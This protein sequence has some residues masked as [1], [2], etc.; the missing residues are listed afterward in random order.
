MTNILGIVLG[1]ALYAC[2]G[3]G[4]YVSLRKLSKYL[5]E[6]VL[7]PSSNISLYLKEID[8]LK[9]S[10]VRK[11]WMI[12]FVLMNFFAAIFSFFTFFNTGYFNLI[13]SIILPIP[14]LIPS[15]WIT[16]YC[17]YKKR[18]SAWLLYL[19]ISLP[20]SLFSMGL[21]ELVQPSFIWSAWMKIFSIIYLAS[22]IY[23][24]ITSIKLRK[25]NLTRRYHKNAL[26]LQEKFNSLSDHRGVTLSS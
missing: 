13:T 6:R 8:T 26:I 1:L 21:K 11:N 25:V 9:E 23:F 4:I 19:I 3:F 16:Y 17:A 18:G 5:A 14:I 12:S 2:I 24:W 10:Q 22:Q 7:L 20:I 15:I